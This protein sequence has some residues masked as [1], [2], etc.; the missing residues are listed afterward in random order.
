[1]AGFVGEQFAMPEAVESLRAVNKDQ[2]RGHMEVVSACDAL[3]LVGILTPGERVP[4]ILGNKAVFRDGV[5]VASLENGK[6][7]DR[8][9]ADQAVLVQAYALLRRSPVETQTEPYRR[10]AA[11]AI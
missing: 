7:V 4:A 9:G 8:S 6:V 1:M 2:S 10:V 11:R 5:P 3:N